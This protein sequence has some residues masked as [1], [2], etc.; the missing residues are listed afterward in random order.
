MK[1]IPSKK[2]RKKKKIELNEY[3]ILNGRYMLRNISVDIT[4]TWDP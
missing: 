4:Y 2:I 3:E 1:K